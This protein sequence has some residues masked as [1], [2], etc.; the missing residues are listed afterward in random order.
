MEIQAAIDKGRPQ[1]AKIRTA[2][3]KTYHVPGGSHSTCDDGILTLASLFRLGPGDIVWDIGVGK[4][5]MAMYFSH[6]TN[7]VVVGT[8]TGR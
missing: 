4:P 6:L 3:S 7:Q 8:D 1:L 5:V 2:M